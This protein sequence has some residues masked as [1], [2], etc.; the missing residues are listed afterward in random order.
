LINFNLI[1]SF[2]LDIINII[3]FKTKIFKPYENI[4]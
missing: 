2:S 1:F 4:K 3:F